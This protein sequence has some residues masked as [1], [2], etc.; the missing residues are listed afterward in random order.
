MVVLLQSPYVST[1][2]LLLIASCCMC[3]SVT[4]NTKQVRFHLFKQKSCNCLICFYLKY[5]LVSHLYLLCAFQS[6][7]SS[8]F[9]Y[10]KL[11]F[12]TKHSVLLPLSSISVLSSYSSIPT[13]LKHRQPKWEKIYAFFLK[14]SSLKVRVG[15][16]ELEFLLTLLS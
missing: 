4:C 6:D 2:W 16:Y 11:V 12:L 15:Y 8:F 7:L 1:D 14:I 13:V 9:S 10:I 3:R 5:H